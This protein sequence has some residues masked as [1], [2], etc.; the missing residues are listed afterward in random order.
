MSNHDSAR[1][2]QIID[3]DIVEEEAP[4]AW[5]EGGRSDC[6]YPDS[7]HETLMMI[8]E[9]MHDIFGEPSK[10]LQ[11]QMKDVGNYFQEVSYAARDW[12]RGE[13]SIKAALSGVDDVSSLGSESDD[14]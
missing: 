7:L 13:L 1:G 8:G 5:D 3:N 11:M 14:E 10:E 6:G 2:N 9:S 12:Q 4:M